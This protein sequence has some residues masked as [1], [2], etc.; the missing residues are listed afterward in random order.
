MGAERRRVV[1]VLPSVWRGSATGRVVLAALTLGATLL[2]AVPCVDAV[3]RTMMGKL[4]LRAP[5]LRWAAL[6][7]MPSMYNFA[8]VVEIRWRDEERPPERL[9]V[10]HYP[11]RA[12]TYMRRTAFAAHPA[13]L[14]AESR[15]GASAVVTRCDVLPVSRGI[16]VVC[17][18][19][20]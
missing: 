2:L 11:L 16:H 8:N 9:W 6:Q 19:E 10:N 18:A 4:H 14:T 7:P 5:Y 12:I 20:R 3:A 13:T 17:E 15:Y 1:E